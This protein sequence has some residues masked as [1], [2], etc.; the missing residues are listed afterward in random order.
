MRQMPWF[1]LYTEARTDAKLRSLSDAQFRVWFNL[2]CYAADQDAERGT[3][4]MSEPFIVALEVAGGDEE[5]LESTCHALSRLRII[6]ERDG[7]V[8]FVNFTRRQYDKPSDTPEQTRMRKQRSRE[9]YRENT[10]TSEIVTPSHAQ[11]KSREEKTR[12]EERRKE[13]TPARP[14]HGRGANYPEDFEKFW[15]QYPNK[16]AKDRALKAWQVLRP[17]AELQAA[18]LAAIARQRQGRDWLKDGGQ[19]IPHPATWLNSAGWMD[20]VTPYVNG[21]GNGRA[22]PAES[23]LERNLRNLWGDRGEPEPEFEDVFETK[24]FVR[25]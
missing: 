22:S 14:A 11:E 17:S 20:E 13:P 4:D 24:G 23:N 5:L 12:V 2:L 7:V 18:I 16:K 25:Q 19:Y 9:K 15:D 8:T 3:I 1:R 10:G 21:N 6:E